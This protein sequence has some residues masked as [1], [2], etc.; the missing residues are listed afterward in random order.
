MM[1]SLPAKIVLLHSLATVPNYAHYGDAGFDLCAVEQAVLAPGQW[2]LIRTGLSIQIP[3]GY[4]IQI[5]PRSGI[6]LKYGVTVLNAPG[7]IDA[8]YTGEIKI[9]L[10]NHGDNY[11]RIESGDRIAQAVASPV[12]RCLFTVVT[13]L[14]QTERG[15]GGFGST[16]IT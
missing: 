12:E 11:F 5:R 1:Q 15:D 10:I 8:N 9:L 4:E 16:G 14:N 7:T 3:I 2:G 13:E 6:A